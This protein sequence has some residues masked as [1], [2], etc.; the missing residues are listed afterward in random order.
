MECHVITPPAYD[1]GFS[2]HPVPLVFQENP[3]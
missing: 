2:V 3:L 1:D